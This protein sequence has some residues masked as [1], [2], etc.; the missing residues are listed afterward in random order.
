LSGPSR[1]GSR[2]S[3]SSNEGS[4]SRKASTVGQTMAKRRS[5]MSLASSHGT[6]ATSGA[7]RDFLQLSRDICVGGNNRDRR[8]QGSVSGL[9]SNLHRNGGTSPDGSERA[10]RQGGVRTLHRILH[11]NSRHLPSPQQDGRSSPRLRHQAT[12]RS[13]RASHFC[14][15]ASSLP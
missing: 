6:T 2:R 9:H 12:M 5:A 10:F 8:L 3:S 13:S 15:L 11:R 14:I 7:A 1:R 4:R